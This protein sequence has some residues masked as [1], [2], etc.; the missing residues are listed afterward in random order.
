MKVILY[1]LIVIIICNIL[2]L[3]I[4]KANKPITDEEY[5][6]FKDYMRKYERNH[7]R[8]RK[9]KQITSNN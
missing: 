1:I 2:W 9:R 6:E 7:P 4:P 3:C 8:W 5:E